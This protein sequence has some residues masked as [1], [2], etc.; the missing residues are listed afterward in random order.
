MTLDTTKLLSI[1]Q[2]LADYGAGLQTRTTPL[3]RSGINALGT[4]IVDISEAIGDL[5]T[6]LANRS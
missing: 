6:E 4:A 2:N 3:D 1:A 5:T